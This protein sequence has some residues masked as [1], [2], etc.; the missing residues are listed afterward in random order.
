MALHAP[1]LRPRVAPKALAGE[2]RQKH[3]A[4]GPQPLAK[5]IQMQDVLLGRVQRLDDVRVALER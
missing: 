5:L 4:D 2:L 1:E 3:I